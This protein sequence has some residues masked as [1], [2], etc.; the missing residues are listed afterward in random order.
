M[1]LSVF[2]EIRVYQ[3]IKNLL[4]FAPLIFSRKLFEP[5]SLEKALLAF[6]AYCLTASAIYVINDLKD[7]E[8]DRLHPTKKN[9]P[10]AA[11]DLSKSTAVILVF[12][13]LALALAV[14]TKLDDT[15]VVVV[16]LIYCIINILYSLYFKHVSIIDCFFIALGF[17]LRIIAG[18]K[19]IDVLPSDFILVVTFFLALMLGF[20]KRKGELK[21]LSHQPENHRKVLSDYSEGM[22]DK[23]IYS[24]STM[25]L[26]SYMFYTIDQNVVAL[27]GHDNLKYSLIFVVYG[28][29][30]FVQL[31]DIDKFHG[32]GDPTTLIYKDKPIQITL[33]LY[34]IFVLYCFY[35][36]WN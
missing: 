11:G 4:I 8:S 1:M 16:L 35:G 36:T 21:V 31:A 27:V 9:R 15:A 33:A 13:C 28:L 22:M 14:L 5:L 12:V 17:E 20:I 3:W 26:I 18:C 25:T 19:A 10:L 24:C 6:L 34:L 29:F 32:E 30:R 2:R 23:F 7:L